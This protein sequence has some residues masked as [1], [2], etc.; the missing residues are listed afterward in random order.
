MIKKT[1]TDQ[2]GRDV[3][4]AWPPQRII[5]TV[6]SQ[7]E[8]LVDL[9][10]PSRIVGRTKF[11]VYP[12]PVIRDIEKIG[13]TKNLDIK[14]IISL[15]PD[16]I[17]ANKE[18]NKKEEIEALSAQCPVWVSDVPNI[19]GMHDM[20]LR[21]GLLTDQRRSAEIMIRELNEMMVA[22]GGHRKRTVAYVIWNNPFM[23]VGGDTFISHMLEVFGLENVFKHYRRYPEIAIQEIE[24]YAPDFVFLSSE[25]FPFKTRHQKDF[26]SWI[27]ASRVILVDG[28]IFSWYG[29]RLL[30]KKDGIQALLAQLDQV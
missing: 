21:V 3:N 27:P 25:P 9:C 22:V 4:I 1:F 12:D 26:A 29:S 16:L 14:K 20:I 17:I 6:P 28:T 8:L 5:S 10:G 2:I 13:G 19:Q 18:E 15:S 30:K 7:T 24:E 23:T 11:C